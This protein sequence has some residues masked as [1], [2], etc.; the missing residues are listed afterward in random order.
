MKY[1]LSL[2]LTFIVITGIAHQIPVP[3]LKSPLT[4]LTGT[5]QPFEIQ[6]LE[7]KL[8]DFE[9]TDKGQIAVLIL[10]TTGEESIEEFS[11]R[12]A[13][14]WKIGSTDKNNGI[15]IT[16]A[17][18]DRKV[19]IEVGYGLEK[20]ITDAE[21]GFIINNI[22]VPAFKNGDFYRGIEGCISSLTGFID[23][24]LPL[25]N[26]Y[27]KTADN[28]SDTNSEAIQYSSNDILFFI[29]LM[30]WV[31]SLIIPFFLIKS[32]LYIMIIT[33]LSIIGTG[34]FLEFIGEIEDLGLT[35]I[36]IVC[37][38][39]GIPFLM[40]LIGTITG[41]KK[42]WTFGESS[43]SGSS[44]GSSSSSGSWG[45]SFSS[46]SWGSSSSSGSS[47]WSGG[48]GS[49]GGGGASGSW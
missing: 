39:D 16:V 45:S 10:P 4:D 13:E 24:T 12:V 47:G 25:I 11:M 35:S 38:I 40:N 31:I 33:I 37:F 28:L 46:S 5:L 17:K 22:V 42:S 19:R 49:F 9:K 36:I 3:E 6:M 8:L 34:Y 44:L 32:K 41:K 48:G 43:Y 2:I 15:I 20:I 29:I 27:D 26:Q 21:A 1:I 7:K 30:I 14:N 18:N 23:G